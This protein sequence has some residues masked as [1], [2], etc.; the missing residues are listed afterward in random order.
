MHTTIFFSLLVSHFGAFLRWNLMNN[1]NNFSV[2]MQL[3][4]LSLMLQP[5]VFIQLVNIAHV[6]WW[7]FC[8]ILCPY[9][10][11]STHFA[12]IGQN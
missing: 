10:C 7:Y 12:Q 2:G 4:I 3:R 9:H 11:N 1:I 8:S 6:R 5:L